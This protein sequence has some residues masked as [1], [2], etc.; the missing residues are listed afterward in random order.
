[1]SNELP[2]FGI[3]LDPSTKD[4]QLT[5]LRQIIG[6]NLSSSISEAAPISCRVQ[7]ND[8]SLEGL[9]HLVAKNA[10]VVVYFENYDYAVIS[11]WAEFVSFFGAKEPWQDYDLCVLP[12]DQD[13]CIAIS[14]NDRMCIVHDGN[15]PNRSFNP[16]ALTRAG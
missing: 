3:P 15:A 12:V 16:D 1:M 11:T 6:Q 7:G 10:R 9:G 8:A 13:W 4:A 14:H 2:N 5:R